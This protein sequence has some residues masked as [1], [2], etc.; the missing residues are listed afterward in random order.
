MSFLYSSADP[1]RTVQVRIFPSAPN[2]QGE[3]SYIVIARSIDEDD[4]STGRARIFSVLGQRNIPTGGVL[5]QH[6]GDHVWLP[7][8]RLGNRR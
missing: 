3:F 2:R 6:Y 8:P 1:A 5:P 4:G 7:R